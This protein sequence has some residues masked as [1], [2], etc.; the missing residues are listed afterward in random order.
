VPRNR[1]RRSRPPAWVAIIGVLVVLVATTWI[2]GSG[3]SSVPGTDATLTVAASLTTAAA[4]TPAD[5]PAPIE[6]AQAKYRRD[7]AL[8]SMKRGVITN[9]GGREKLVALTFDDGPG[10]LT[11]KFLALLNRLDAPATFYVQGSLLERYPEVLKATIAGGHELGVHAW[12]HRDLREVWGADFQ[13]E[14]F[15]TQAAIKEITGVDAGTMRPPYGAVDDRVLRDAAPARMVQVLWDVDTNDW[16]GRSAGQIADHVI[17]KATA[18]SIVLMHDGGDTRQATLRSL[19]RIV[20]GLR[21]KGVEF[22]TVSEL[23]ARDPPEELRDEDE[24]TVTDEAPAVTGPG[25]GPSSTYGA[26]SSEG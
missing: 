5:G 22:V 18:G 11:M 15:G 7:M 17:E 25:P 10:P 20:E 24:V 13:R 14:V 6:P 26:P 1:R 9:G 12:S 8:M 21:A 16:R 4:V 2:V 23:L 3:G 19:P